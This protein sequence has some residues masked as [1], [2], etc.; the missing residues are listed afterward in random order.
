[1][2][3]NHMAP[4]VVEVL[5]DPWQ[6]LQ[7]AL[8]EAKAAGLA[9]DTG[10]MAE[11]TQG[12]YLESVHRYTRRGVYTYIHTHDIYIYIYIYVYTYTHVN[13]YRGAYSDI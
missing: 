5:K 2:A 10:L 8:S 1:M 3:P 9:D 7:V 13:V 4:L 6:L 12:H 11:A